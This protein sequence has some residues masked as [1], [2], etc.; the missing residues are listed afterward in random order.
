MVKEN[1][2]AIL[3]LDHQGRLVLP[4]A[5]RK[6]LG[7]VPG[8]RMVAWVEGGRL[9]LVPWERLEAE[10]WTELEDVAG[11]LAAELIRERRLEAL[12]DG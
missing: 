1:E 3:K 8:T 5:L 6:A 10:I 9:V 12:K 2:P 4:K 11:D 7:V